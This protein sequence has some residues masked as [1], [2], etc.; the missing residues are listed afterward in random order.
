MARVIT[1]HGGVAVA[2]PI[3]RSVDPARP[4]NWQPITS[5]APTRIELKA[6]SGRFADLTRDTGMRLQMGL[7][8]RGSFELRLSEVRAA[9]FHYT[10]WQRDLVD[11]AAPKVEW[12]VELS[13]MLRERSPSPHAPNESVRNRILPYALSESARNRVGHVVLFVGRRLSA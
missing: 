6:V 5:T 2:A 4:A 10:Q 13:V 1:K 11:P 7:A 9:C 8:A 3:T 12:D